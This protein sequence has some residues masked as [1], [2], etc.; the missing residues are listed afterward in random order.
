MLGSQDTEPQGAQNRGL[1]PPRSWNPPTPASPRG[2]FVNFKSFGGGAPCSWW[3]A[4]LGQ[5]LGLEVTVGGFEGLG[6][7][8]ASGA[9]WPAVEEALRLLRCS[10]DFGREELICA[11]SYHGVPLP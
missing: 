11:A 6:Q 9:A 8:S 2:R 3:E 10:R 1:L 5:W 7:F 4:G